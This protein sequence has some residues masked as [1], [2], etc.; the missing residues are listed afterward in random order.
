M[1]LEIYSKVKVYKESKNKCIYLVK[2]EIDGLLYIQRELKIS[3]KEVYNTLKDI[4]SLYIPEI[5]ELIE[6]DNKLIVI[7]EY[8]N[9]ETLEQCIMNN[10]IKEEEKEQIIT[11]LCEALEI[12][13]NHKIIHRDI[14]PANIFYN[15]KHIVLF[16]F[17]ISRIYDENQEKDTTILGSVGYAAPEQ[18]GFTQSDERTDIYALGIIIKQ[19]YGET[20]IVKKATQIDPNK[21]YQNVN[22]LKNAIL[23]NNESWAIPGFRS[24]KLSHIIIS[25]FFYIFVIYGVFSTETEEYEPHSLAEFINNIEL[26]IFIFMIV[27]FIAN[28]RNIKKY[29]LFKNNNNKIVRIIGQL[30]TLFIILFIYMFIIT[31]FR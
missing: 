14:K 23:N 15:H 3:N 31:L 25:T 11:Q 20:D 17:D 27:A 5:Y 13:H 6:E 30:L 12:L 9:Y 18:F 21:R 16:D 24:H 22:E 28:Y 7:E 10:E 8:I 1:S 26:I 2:N 4:H 19:L 29:S